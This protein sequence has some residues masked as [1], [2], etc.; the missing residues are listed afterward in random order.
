MKS[1]LSIHDLSPQQ[2]LA[3]CQQALIHDNNPNSSEALSN[4]IVMTLFFE[5]STRTRFS[6][7][8]AA[9]RLNAKILSF[10]PD[11]SSLQKGESFADTVR[12]AAAYADIL[13]IRH[14]EE[15]T[16]VKAAAISSAPIIN[17]GDGKNEHPTQTLLDLYTIFKQL[18]RLDG[19]HI[20]VAGDLR[21]GR[22]PHSLIR[23]LSMFDVKITLA[24]PPDF[25][26]PDDLKAL[27]A[28]KIVMETSDLSQALK[29]DFLYMTRVQKER[30][31]PNDTGYSDDFILTKQML[32]QNASPSLKVLHP[33]PRVNEITEDVD[34]TPYALYFEQ[35]KNG[36]YMRIA[37]LEYVAGVFKC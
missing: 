18:Q 13:I 27:I 16:A 28:D 33:L 17:A 1:L 35:A 30:F 9:L 6:F 8:S 23:A 4:K 32:S 14:P 31:N 11:V 34:S 37:I 21:Y 19:Y 2:I 7:E 24:S 12:M 36:V 10:T 22:A 3:L 26:L 25:T 29:S 15:G 20:T 5:P